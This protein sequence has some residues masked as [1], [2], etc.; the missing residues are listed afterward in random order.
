M[1]WLLKNYQISKLYPY[2]KNFTWNSLGTCTSLKIKRCFHEIYVKK[3]MR[4]NFHNFHCK[5]EI[6]VFTI[7][8]KLRICA[9]ISNRPSDATGCWYGNKFVISSEFKWLANL[10]STTMLLVNKVRPILVLILQC[11]KTRII[12]FLKRIREIDISS[13]FL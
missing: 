1:I 5:G 9:R 4:A 2:R 10:I 13:N 12:L 8:K 11:G 6:M 7:D 3:Y